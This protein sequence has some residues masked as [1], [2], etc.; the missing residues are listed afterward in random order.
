MGLNY[1]V[2]EI[3]EGD[4]AP[5]I[6]VQVGR[7]CYLNY[8]DDPV[9]VA[10]YRSWGSPEEAEAGLATFGLDQNSE[11]ELH[12]SFAA[13]AE[14]VACTTAAARGSFPWLPVLLVGA[15]AFVWSK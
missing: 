9:A 14:V 15:A 5:F 11:E 7:T 1:R 10:T 3:G 6:I 13:N 2:L 8:A 4:D 12:R